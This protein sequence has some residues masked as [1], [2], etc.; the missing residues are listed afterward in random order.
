MGHNDL[1]FGAYIAKKR[2]G[3]GIT[4]RAMAEKLGITPVYL[5]DIEKGKR[6][7]P[8][9]ALLEKMAAM[10]MIAGED[11]NH[12]FDLA[13]KGR[14]EVAADLTDYIRENEYVRKALRLAKEVATE[15][16]WQ[17][18]LTQLKSK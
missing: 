9:K 12:L 6:N 5:S 11:R 15:D 17:Q 7:P 18:F 10:L 13:G 16:D 8:H 1:K 2:I 4:L 3:L 14:G